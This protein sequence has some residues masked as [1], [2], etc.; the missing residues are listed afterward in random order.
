MS[1]AV[2][3]LHD[4]GAILYF[5]EVDSNVVILNPQW[6]AQL[7]ATIITFKHS[8]ARDGL[9]CRSD[10]HGLWKEV[11]GRLTYFV[12]AFCIGSAVYSYFLPSF[13]SCLSLFISSQS[14]SSQSA[15]LRFSMTACEY[16]NRMHAVPIQAAPLSRLPFGEFWHI[17]RIRG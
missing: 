14:Y 10:L 6:V 4:L 8:F 7:F 9:L 16:T 3:F 11:L 17:L 13:F 15:T 12:V 1:T 5:K 2:A